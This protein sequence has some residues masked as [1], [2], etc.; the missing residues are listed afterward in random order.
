MFALRAADHDRAAVVKTTATAAEGVDELLA[1]IDHHA[2]TVSPDRAERR[3]NRAHRLLASRAGVLLRT[4]GSGL[5]VLCTAL[6]R[7]E[8][9]LDDCAR[10]T[11]DLKRPSTAQ[12]TGTLP[13]VDTSPATPR[14]LCA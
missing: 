12:A 14:G 7:R 9:T 4:G 3:R 11:L 13:G 10:A 5:D 8:R 6:E 1:A 2:T